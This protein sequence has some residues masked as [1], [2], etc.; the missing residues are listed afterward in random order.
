MTPDAQP[1]SE[2]A[3]AREAQKKALAH[4]TY[5]AGLIDTYINTISKPK[6]ETLLKF[7]GNRDLQSAEQGNGIEVVQPPVMMHD[8]FMEAPPS[9]AS[10]I[11]SCSMLPDILMTGKVPVMEEKAVAL[12]RPERLVYEAAWQ[13]VRMLAEH[14]PK[15]YFRKKW[16]AGFHLLHTPAASSTHDSIRSELKQDIEALRKDNLL[17][18]QQCSEQ[19]AYLLETV[20]PLTVAEFRTLHAGFENR[21]QTKPGEWAHSE[22]LFYALRT[23]VTDSGLRGQLQ[24][25]LEVG[26]KSRGEFGPHAQR[27]SVG[28]QIM[29]PKAPA[30]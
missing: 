20:M 12:Y 18:S 17:G 9:A 14:D 25:L 11:K 26:I 19:F 27:S 8:L 21:N 3:Q 22:Q 10:L 2:K 28:M 1:E 4:R 13:T 30:P 15:K 5:N 16:A 29:P 24:K 7:I 23:P 6:L